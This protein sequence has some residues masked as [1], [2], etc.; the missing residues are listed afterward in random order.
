LTLISCQEI[1]VGKMMPTHP[2]LPVFVGWCVTDSSS[3]PLVDR[4]SSAPLVMWK[5]IHGQNV[6]EVFAMYRRKYKDELNWR[7]QVERVL[8]WSRQLFSALACLHSHGVTS[9][10][11]PIFSERHE[12]A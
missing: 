2:N 10:F 8:G 9:M 4:S 12:A 1:A 6:L 7:P 3:G 5:R 11:S